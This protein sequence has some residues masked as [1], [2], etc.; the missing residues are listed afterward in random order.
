MVPI[1]ELIH[2][3][4]LMSRMEDCVAVAKK[5]QKKRKIDWL[6]LRTRV[7]VRTIPR[8]SYVRPIK[9]VLL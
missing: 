9:Y 4:L 5:L 8:V 3:N 1:Q 6:G 7:Y 2:H